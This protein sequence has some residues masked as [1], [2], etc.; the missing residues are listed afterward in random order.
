LRKASHGGKS[1]APARPHRYGE[2]GNGIGQGLRAEGLT[3]IFAYDTAAFEGVFSDLIQGRPRRLAWSSCVARPTS[4][5]RPISSS[6]PSGNEC[7]PAADAIARHLAPKHLYI[8]IGSATPKVKQQVGKSLA[9]SGAQ[10]A[11]GGIMGSPIN[12]GHRI[13]TKTSGPAAPAFA[14]ALNPWGMRM[15]VVSPMLGAGSGI[16]IVRS[17]VMKEWRRSFTNARSPARA[18][19]SRTR[20]SPRSASSWTSAPSWTR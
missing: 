2:V 10:I 18:T 17:V 7:V 12:D 20:S 11:D 5:D 8:D 19:A 9:A 6:S 15:E 13:L 14:A 4:P 1:S 16:K 3:Q